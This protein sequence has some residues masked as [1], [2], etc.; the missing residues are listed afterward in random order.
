MRPGEVVECNGCHLHSTGIPH[1][2]AGV[3]SAINQGAATTGLPFPNT[4]VAWVAQMGETMAEAKERLTCQT[5]CAT[6]NLSVDLRYT[7]L[8]TDPAIRAKDPDINYLYSDLTTALPVAAACVA[9][10]TAA[11]R[12]VINYE[13][14]IHPLWG[15]QRKLFAADGVTEIGDHTCNTCHASKDAMNVAQLPA[16]QLDLSDGESEE[17]A[18]QFR[19]YREL[20]VGDNIQELT[21]G[22]LV[23]RL[24]PVTDAAGNPLFEVDESGN[25]IVDAN[26]QPIPRLTT[27]PA[28]GPFMS[29]TGANASS[30][31]SFFST[32]AIHA[33]W[34]SPA[35]LRLLAEWLDIGAQYYN[36]PFDAPLN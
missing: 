26:G 5:S 4:T 35:E 12:I 27:L 36:N 16:G 6:L 24:V 11:C 1:G 15:V 2:R 7:D 18:L 17:N 25:V 33:G 30:F 34:L 20:L 31:F 29:T 14:H 22:A 19:A 13:A 10:W 21:N 3:A 9:E 23:D 32:G 8:W 28:P